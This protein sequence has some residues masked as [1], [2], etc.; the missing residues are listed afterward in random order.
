MTGSRLTEGRLAGGMGGGGN[1]D[2]EFADGL[3]S[4]ADEADGEGNG[5]AGADHLLRDECV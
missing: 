1:V 4:G 5:D 2:F 3:E